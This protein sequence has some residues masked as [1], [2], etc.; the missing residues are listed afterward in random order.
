MSNLSQFDVASA[1]LEHLELLNQ[2]NQ[3]PLAIAAQFRILLRS[4]QVNQEE[5][6]Q[7]QAIPSPPIPNRLS[8]PIINWK[9]LR[10]KRYEHKLEQFISMKFKPKDSTTVSYTS[11]LP[12]DSISSYIRTPCIS[13]IGFSQPTY[14]IS[15]L[16]S[17]SMN[18]DDVLFPIAD[19]NLIIKHKP[20]RVSH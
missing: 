8:Y 7:V 15:R 11:A 20:K 17:T 12:D 9:H 19:C 18:H 10:R 13:P 3:N 2:P 14:T 4:K 6:S 5:C 16:N 1:A